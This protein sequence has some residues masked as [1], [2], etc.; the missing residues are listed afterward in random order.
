[1]HFCETIFDARLV[2]LWSEK[3][4]EMYV[5]IR[6]MAHLLARTLHHVHNVRRE[7][8]KTNDVHFR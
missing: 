2:Y 1:M 4:R 8:R 6:Q 7:Q 3:W 5:A